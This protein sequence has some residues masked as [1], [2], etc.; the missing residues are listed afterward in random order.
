MIRFLV[1]LL[2]VSVSLSG[3]V[4]AQPDRTAAMEKAKAK[5]EK[6]MA[7]Y[8]EALLAGMDKSIAQATKTGIRPFKK[9]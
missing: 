6:D 1:L 2:L 5:F 9:S 8:D 7:K 4:V 3:V